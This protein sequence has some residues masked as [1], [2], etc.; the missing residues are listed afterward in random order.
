MCSSARRRWAQLSIAS[1]ASDR[2]R[3]PSSGRQ[4]RRH[5]SER[6]GNRPAGSPGARLLPVR[7]DD[8][9]PGRLGPRATSRA[10]GANRAR[11]AARAT[12]R[13]GE[14]RPRA[15]LP[16]GD[17]G[18]SAARKRANQ[19][20]ACSNVSGDV[21]FHRFWAA[22]SSKALRHSQKALRSSH[23]SYHSGRSHHFVHAQARYLPQNPL[24]GSK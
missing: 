6:R 9:H 18:A 17:P 10:L 21:P 15:R 13:A 1:S 20:L 2:T 24:T 23:R 8:R 11:G 3:T 16:Q 12:F 19:A 14:A 5:P 4:L 7:A 22:S